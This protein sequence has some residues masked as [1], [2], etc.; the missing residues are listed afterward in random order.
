MF[1]SPAKTM[2]SSTGVP[3]GCT[4]HTDINKQN[5]LI[6]LFCPCISLLYSCIVI[7]T[8][9]LFILGIFRREKFDS[10]DESF[11][12]ESFRPHPEPPLPLDNLT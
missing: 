11:R 6:I 9:S 7:K 4:A 8:V 10:A 2:K 1:A 3:V 12:E 5:K